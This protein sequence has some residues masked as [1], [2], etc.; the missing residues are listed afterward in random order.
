VLVVG[1]WGFR[2]SGSGEATLDEL[3][4]AVLYEPRADRW[5][6]AG[7]MA[8]ARLRHSASLMADGRVLVVGG[9]S[10][11]RTAAMSAE[12]F[13]PRTGPGTTRAVSRMAGTAT[14]PLRSTTGRSW[15]SGE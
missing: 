13:D 11:D 6:P 2:R 7:Q 4:D 5:T 9:M 14:G 15:W 8:R 10:R 3:R 12:A 1:G